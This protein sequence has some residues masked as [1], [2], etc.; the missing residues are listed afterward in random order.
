MP[1][2]KIC[3]ERWLAYYEF[4]LS[5]SRCGLR[6]GE[7]IALQLRDIDFTKHTIMVRRTMPIHRHVGSP[8]T[9]SSKRTVDMS[10]QLAEA[11]RLMIKKRRAEYLAAGKAEIPEWLFCNSAGN[12]LD[13]SRFAKRWNHIQM[14]AKVQRR[15]RP[16]DL[17]HTF[18][19][20]NLIAGKALT[21]VSAQL[22]HKNPKIT[23]EIY[24]RW[25][26]GADPGPTDT[27]DEKFE[28]SSGD[29]ITRKEN[30][31]EGGN[32]TATGDNKKR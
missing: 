5:Q 28:E 14:V 8:K 22:G 21:Y 17:R 18:A 29:N 23:L 15:R 30:N 27:L 3:R 9:L 31:D 19:S 32:R 4:I 26:K 25:V 7:A 20:L 11:L 24:A 1:W 12:P 6:I 2:K 16:H 13:Y 10:P